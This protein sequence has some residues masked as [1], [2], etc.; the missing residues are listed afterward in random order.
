M[1]IA[2]GACMLALTRSF[3]ATILRAG[4]AA[5][6]GGRRRRPGP[7]PEPP[8][9]NYRL[10]EEIGAGGMG[11]V[12]RAEH[13]LLGRPAAIKMIR[14]E[15]VSD[16]SAEI[17]AITRER[18]R[19]EAQAAA[20]LRSPH[21]IELYDFGVGRDGAFYHV[22][23]LL[24]GVSFDDLVRRFGPVP[25]ARAVHLMIQACHSLGEAHARGLIH[26]DVKPS[27]LFAAR[28]GLAV[29]FVKVLDFGLVTWS[30]P[31]ASTD[32]RLTA[33][34]QATGTPAFIAP[35]VALGE[36]AVDRRADVYALGCVLYWLL[37][38]R[39]VF[40]ASN[41]LRM[42]QLHVVEPPEPPSRHAVEPV[43]AELDRLVLACLAKR[44]DERPADAGDLGRRLA[45]LGLAERWSAE[46][47]GRWW[48]TH[49]PAAETPGGWGNR[50]DSAPTLEV[51]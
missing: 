12:F 6:P 3:T 10:G 14:P 25:P 13:R 7:L 34:N 40:E 2:S 36:E 35:E 11:R 27:N 21:T 32:G 30:T 42:M 38:G 31:A 22:M 43:P 18:F 37:T 5:L 16:P 51:A 9:G 41:P 39:W 4:R 47:A 20:L 33:P 49:L 24:E 15:L 26:R 1:M 50:A 44:P 48:G 19:R 17:S 29:D 28:V 46:R 8:L 45:A 23:E